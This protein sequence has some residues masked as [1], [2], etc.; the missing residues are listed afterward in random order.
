MTIERIQSLLAESVGLLSRMEHLSHEKTQVIKEGEIE[1]LKQLMAL[2]QQAVMEMGQLEARR[3]QLVRAYFNETSE[4]NN[5]MNW[6]QL[7]LGGKPKRQSGNDSIGGNSD[8]FDK[9]IERAPE[10]V[11]N[12]LSD[13]RLELVKAVAA[14]KENNHLNQQLLQQSM[15]WVQM[16]LDMIQPPQPKPANYEHPNKNRPREPFYSRIDS[17]A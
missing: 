16:N 11:R 5:Q 17:K 15:Q 6:D 9:L 13:L 14:L 4:G 3:G 8:T 12:S 10:D 1:K 2:E 7:T